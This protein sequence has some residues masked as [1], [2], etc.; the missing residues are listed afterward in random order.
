MPASRQTIVEHLRTATSSSMLDGKCARRVGGLPMPR[1]EPGSSGIVALRMA[2]DQRREMDRPLRPQTSPLADC[3]AR[4]AEKIARDDEMKIAVR[5]MLAEARKK[6]A[7]YLAGGSG[8]RSYATRS[9][10]SENQKNSDDVHIQ[11]GREC[12]CCCEEAARWHAEDARAPETAPQ[13][14][15]EYLRATK[16]M[17]TFRAEIDEGTRESLRASRAAESANAP[18]GTSEAKQ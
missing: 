2:K 13:L 4:A 7:R 18:L 9:P 17:Q 11:N 12:A 8:T 14:L 15:A 16:P 10:R 1:P 3:T 5:E 6:T